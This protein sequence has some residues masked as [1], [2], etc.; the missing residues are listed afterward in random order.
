MQI[1]YASFQDKKYICDKDVH[2]NKILIDSKLNQQEI[3]LVELKNKI[4]GFLRFNYFW[5]N[6]P[7]I[8]LIWLD[9]D[10]RGMRFGS[11]VLDFWEKEMNGKGYTFVLTSSMADEGAQNF[12]RKNGYQDCGS[13]LLPDEPLEIIFRKEFN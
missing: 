2:L 1:R 10:Y 4:I 12:F 9:K 8:N 3:I 7:F 6:T 13:L 11:K 5:D